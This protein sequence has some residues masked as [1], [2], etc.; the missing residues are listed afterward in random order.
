MQVLAHRGLWVTP[1]KR[2]TIVALERAL[3]FGYGVELDLRDLAGELVGGAR[4]SRARGPAVRGVRARVRRLRPGG[5]G[6][7]Q[8]ELARL[9]PLLATALE[10]CTLRN[11]FVFDWAVPDARSYVDRGLRLFTRLSEHEPAPAFYA[12][13]A[14]VWLDTFSED[15]TD[16]RPIAEHLERGKQ[17]ALVSP[18]LHGREH[19]P[20]WARYA[21]MTVVR[22]HELLL[23]TDHPAAAADL[24]APRGVAG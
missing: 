20:A 10:S 5:A 21:R 1:G 2:N 19:Q 14:G 6:G 18:E 3:A 22:S 11:Y 7:P 9:A 23:C 12:A 8:R 13:A 4:T 16:E 24:F 17:V 15:V